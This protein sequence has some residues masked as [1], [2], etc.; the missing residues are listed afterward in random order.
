MRGIR[1]FKIFSFRIFLLWLAG[2]A[3]SLPLHALEYRKILSKRWNEVHSDH[4]VV[5]TDMEPERAINLVTDLEY[6]RHFVQKVLHITLAEDSE[7]LPILAIGQWGNY[8]NLG[9]QENIGGVFSVGPYG[10]SA[11]ANV[12]RYQPGREKSDPARHTLLHEYMHF[13]LRQPRSDINQ[14]VSYPSWYEE[15]IAEYWATFRLDGTKIIVG[16][17]DVIAQRIF[18]LYS[19]RPGRSLIDSESLFL[20]PIPNLVDSSKE[21]KLAL[22]NYY[23]RAFFLVH[24]LNSHPKLRAAT[25]DYL[26]FLQSGD[27]VELSLKKAFNSDFSQLDQAVMSYISGENSMAIRKFSSRE[28]EF[29]FPEFDINVRKLSKAEKY[30]AF[31]SFLWNFAFI[32]ADLKTRQELVQ[33]ALK[34]NP[35]SAQLTAF[36]EALDSLEED[37]KE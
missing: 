23:A 19:S 20:Q 26:G 11:V 37:R 27:S 10:Y 4:F 15:G 28:G 2:L 34:Y 31:A 24:F 7:A 29:K 5:V 12:L 13:L 8:V 9:F 14:V 36:N 6:F 21:G 18:D 1:D 22:G 25:D 35:G 3:F 16:E 33:R 17:F 30:A 32:D